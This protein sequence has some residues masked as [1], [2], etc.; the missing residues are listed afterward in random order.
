M[1]VT[2]ARGTPHVMDGIRVGPRPKQTFTEQQVVNGIELPVW[3]EDD[4][5]FRSHMDV[6]LWPND[7]IRFVEMRN[8]EQELQ[9]DNFET[10]EDRLSAMAAYDNMSCIAAAEGFTM[11]PPT[12]E[13]E[14]DTTSSFYMYISLKK[15]TLTLM[16]GDKTIRV[17]T[18]IESSRRGVGDGMNSKQTPVGE[19]TITKEPKHR[20]GPVFRLSG[21]QGW[22]R[23]ILIHQDNTR[24]SGSNGCLHLRNL[25]EMTELFNL[26]PSG[27]HL[28]I[29]K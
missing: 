18:G 7:S 24:D 14:P 12:E 17:F 23:G 5:S 13:A 15:R 6:R 27:A 8:L 26:V 16:E 2:S 28:K 9:D 4:E 22:T 10:P 3:G 19:F 21:Y 29:E 25:K 20:Y 1:L 11:P